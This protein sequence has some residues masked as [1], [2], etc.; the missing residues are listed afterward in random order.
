MMPARWYVPPGEQRPDHAVSPVVCRMTE[1]GG[2][3]GA[4]PGGL[5]VGGPMDPD[6]QG[7]QRHSAGHW[8]NLRGASPLQMIRLDP[9]PRLV[10][11][12]TVAGSLPDHLW[13]VP[14]LVSPVYDEENS[15][16][17]I[18]FK[19]GLDRVWT[20]KEWDLP[21]RLVD[22]RRRLLWTF[23]EVAGERMTLASADA[24][25]MALDLLSEGQQFD[26]EEIIAEGWVSEVL[27]VRTL[28]AG[29]DRDIG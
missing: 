7:W 18:S 17:I 1:T 15:S 25:A 19:S 4:V 16:T 14:V 10:E 21:D 5:C 29:T 13:R 22:L 9:H 12:R 24:V 2:P 28:C 27:V 6:E 20:G 23:Q 3:P 11:W 26:R 8:F